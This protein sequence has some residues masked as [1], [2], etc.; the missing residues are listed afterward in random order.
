M[1]FDKIAVTLSGLSV[2]ANVILNLRYDNEI[3]FK[4]NTLIYNKT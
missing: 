3:G 1:D 4:I 2:F